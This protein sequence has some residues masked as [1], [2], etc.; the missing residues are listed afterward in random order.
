MCF[1]GTSSRAGSSNAGEVM[2]LDQEVDI[3]ADVGNRLVPFE[4]KYRPPGSI[5]LKG[6][7]EFCGERKVELGYVI[8]HDLTDFGEVPVKAK[9]PN[10]RILKI[11]APLACYWL[12]KSEIE[13]TQDMEPSRLPMG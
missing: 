7:I 1:S 8:T 3:I 5:K 2:I 9:L 11:P 4:V 6:L 13:N 10:S 12:G